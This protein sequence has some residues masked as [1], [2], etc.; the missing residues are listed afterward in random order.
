[1]AVIGY[2]KAENLMKQLDWKMRYTAH[3]E[4]VE[5]IELYHPKRP[6]V[7]AVRKDSGKKLLKECRVICRCENDETAILCYDH[8]G[9]NEDL[10]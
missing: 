3:G 5:K 4:D 8:A 1:M 2:E 7:Y 6:T 9:S 10:I